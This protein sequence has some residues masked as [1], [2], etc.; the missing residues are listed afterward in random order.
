MTDGPMSTSTVGNPLQIDHIGVQHS[1]LINLRQNRQA[2]IKHLQQ[3][4]RMII[5]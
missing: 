5:E 4:R 1:R 3:V 2:F